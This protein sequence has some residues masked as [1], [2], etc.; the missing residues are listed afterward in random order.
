MTLETNGILLTL[1]LAR[2]IARCK[3]PFVSVSIDSP[4][5][6][7]HDVFR[8]VPGSFEKAKIGIKNRVSVGLKPQ[9]IMTL[10]R[11]NK[12]QLEEIIKL[13]ESLGA[14]SVKFNIVQPIAR[15][16]A[17][18]KGKETLDIRE[19]VELGRYVDDELSRK[20]SL[21]LFYDHPLAFRR[22]SRIFGTNNSGCGVCGVLGIL[23]VL[24]DGSYALCG[25]GETVKELVFGHI[26]QDSLSDVWNG[27]PI[28]KELREG[29]PNRL[30]G[31]CGDC[32]MKHRCLG[33]FIAQ[34]YYRGKD[35]W[36]PFWYCAA[37][38]NEGFFPETRLAKSALNV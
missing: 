36:Q 23:G 13:A 29:L 32:L 30:E 15:G 4:D 10:M 19:L 11:T 18:H 31:I 22:L 7:I 28:L 12:N 26:V 20:T 5:A 24:A 1:E 27:T 14:G 33:S 9:I 6:K 2:L 37:A 8:G 21:K 3:N 17:M 34:N 35:L 25:I 38:Y 16:E